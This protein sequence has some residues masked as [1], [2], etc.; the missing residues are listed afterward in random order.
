VHHRSVSETVGAQAILGGALEL[1]PQARQTDNMRYLFTRFPP[2]GNSS[3]HAVKP[4]PASV[5]NPLGSPFPMSSSRAVD[6]REALS[7]PGRRAQR[8]RAVLGTAPLT[9]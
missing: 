1:V 3:A 9:T 2:V 7:S 4:P 8:R 6:G 5:M